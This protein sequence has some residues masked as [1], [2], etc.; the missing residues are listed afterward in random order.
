MIAKA[1]SEAQGNNMDKIQPREYT[2]EMAAEDCKIFHKSFTRP[3][4]PHGFDRQG[5]CGCEWSSATHGDVCPQCQ[6]P[7]M[8]EPA[9][10]IDEA[11][12]KAASQYGYFRITN[13]PHAGRVVIKSPSM[14]IGDEPAAYF[15]N[16]LAWILVKDLVQY[17]LEPVSPVFTYT[18]NV[19]YSQATWYPD[20]SNTPTHNIW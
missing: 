17:S 12:M 19:D 20:G 6:A 16:S 5:E 9:I 11:L 7:A 10:D 14:R 3:S 15:A 4:S 18:A 8:V 13:G 2:P 1:D